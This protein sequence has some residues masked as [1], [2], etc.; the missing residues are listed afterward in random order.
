MMAGSGDIRLV[1]HDHNTNGLFGTF[2]KLFPILIKLVKPMATSFFKITVLCK[3]CNKAKK[4]FIKKLGI[5]AYK[6]LHISIVILFEYQKF[7]FTG[8]YF[9]HCWS[10]LKS[11]GFLD[12]I[13]PKTKLNELLARAL[14]D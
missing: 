12:I 2:L 13:Q 9:A 6:R 5:S 10:V 4:K 8:I 11:K 7:P 1:Q 14:I 3:G